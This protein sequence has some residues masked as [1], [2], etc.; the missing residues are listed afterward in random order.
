[1]LIIKITE[2]SRYPTKES[3]SLQK[4]ILLKIKFTYL[5]QIDK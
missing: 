1:M 4:I 5:I 2:P 3:I